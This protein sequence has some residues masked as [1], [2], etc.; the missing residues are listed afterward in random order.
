MSQHDLWSEVRQSVLSAFGEDLKELR[1]SAEMTH[2]VLG[3]RSQMHGTEIGLLERG[4]REPRLGTM[5]KLAVALGVPFE[6]L[7]DSPV[8]S[9]NYRVA[10]DR[11]AQ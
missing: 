4:Q 5:L 10:R 2:R 6:C 11:R 3:E 7:T 8:G 1:T 9:F